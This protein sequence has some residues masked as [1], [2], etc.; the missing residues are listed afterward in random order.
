VDA[1]SSALCRYG[2]AEGLPVWPNRDPVGEAGGAN[3][4]RT[5]SNQPV[6]RVD[7]DGRLIWPGSSIPGTDIKVESWF[8]NMLS[9]AGKVERWQRNG[10]LYT[11]KQ[12][13]LC[14]RPGMNSGD[15]QHCI[16]GCLM[17]VVS[18]GFGLYV[19]ATELTDFQWSDL[20]S[21]YVGAIFGLTAGGLEGCEAR[22]KE[23]VCIE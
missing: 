7:S 3:L 16:F 4:Y 12:F 5:V 22:C 2:A 11:C 15:F 14:Y 21:D 17:T 10:H 8:E 19:G 1:D 6:S 13:G 20:V 9:I 18:P 23:Y